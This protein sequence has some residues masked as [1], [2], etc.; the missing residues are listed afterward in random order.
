MCSSDLKQKTA[1]EIQAC[2]WSSDVCSSDLPAPLSVYGA[3]KL[4]GEEA[5]RDAGGLSPSFSNFIVDERLR[6]KEFGILDRL[7]KLGIEQKHPDQAAT[8]SLVG[9][10]YFRPPAGE[11]DACDRKSVV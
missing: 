11:P 3:S 2:G 7:T 8:R 1:Y 9:K 5:I 4:A 6:E 10:F